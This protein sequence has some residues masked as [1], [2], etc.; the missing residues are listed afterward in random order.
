VQVLLL[1]LVACTTES[2]CGDPT[3]D[4]RGGGPVHTSTGLGEAAELLNRAAAQLEYRRGH[5]IVP[6]AGVQEPSVIWDES[7]ELFRM[8]YTGTTW[9]TIELE[10]EGEIYTREVKHSKM[11]YATSPDGLTWTKHP[12]PIFEWSFEY[13]GI[14]S[15]NFPIHTNVIAD[16]GLGYHLFYIT[17]HGLGH[18][19]SA[20]GIDWTRNEGNPLVAKTWLGES[21]VIM[22]GGPSAILE[23]DG[24][25][26]LFHM[27]SVPGATTWGE[28]GMA[29]GLATGAC[30]DE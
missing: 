22:Y 17:N 5:A 2:A 18:A 28:G 21:E 27:R 1:E 15:W 24:S 10:E 20:D 12:E 4:V 9:G 3:H 6:E 11:G 8:W 14:E 23:E 16:P 26:D 19:Y 30:G 7:A 13:F 25:I 29:L